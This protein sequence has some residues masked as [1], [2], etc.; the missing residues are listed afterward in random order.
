M[1]S[2]LVFFM[3]AGFAFVESG[4]TRT[5][6][7]I[8][9]AIKN[10]TDLGFSFIIYWV[11]G[12]AFM[13][14][15]SKSGIIGTTLFM[16]PLDTPWLSVFFLFQAMFCSTSATIV[17]GA[18]AERMRYSMYILI[19]IV[20]SSI[21]YPVTGHWGWG[22][23]L[24]GS[25]SGWLAERGFIDFAGSTIVHSV[26][27]W[28]ALAALIII[29]P[30]EGRFV[31]GEAPRKINGSD[32][33]AAVVGVIILWFGWFGFN[34]G[35]TLA[36]DTSISIIII[37]TSLA[38]SAGMAGALFIGWIIFKKPDVEFVTNGAI[39]GLVAITANC[40]AVTPGASIII[41]AVGGAIMLGCSQLFL[42]L[43]INDAVGAIPVHLAAGIWGTLA[44]ALFG[45]P[46]L[47]GTGL[48][49]W[50]Q[51][52]V[53]VEGILAT[54]LW[55]FGVSFLFFYTINK[56]TPF[57]ISPEEEEQ[58]LNIA[59][60][61][62][63]T[64]IYDFYRVLDTQAESGR[65]DLRAPVEP[66]TEI[67][68]IARRYNNLLENLENHV[69]ARSDYLAILN[70]ITDGLFLIDNTMTISGQYSKSMETIFEENGIKGDNFKELLARLMPD[71]EMQNKY[72]YLELLFKESIQDETLEELNPFKDIEIFID[73][74]NGKFHNK[75]LDIDF[76]RIFHEGKVIRVM[77]IIQDLTEQAL[78]SQEVD[79]M[80]K[81]AQTEM[82][83][84]YRIQHINPRIF[85]EFLSQAENSIA[86]INAVLGSVD[87]AP[88][89]KIDTMYRQI[90]T[91]K[92]D[93][94][95][96]ELDFVANKAHDF[97]NEIE[98]LK[99]KDDIIN[100]DFIP[101]AVHLSE[102]MGLFSQ[103]SNIGSRLNA[104]QCAFVEDSV[105]SDLI[106]W[107]IK[108]LIDRTNSEKGHNIRFVFKSFKSDIIPQSLRKNIRDIFVQL[109]RN[110]LSHG[111]ESPEER[112]SAG[113]NEDSL[114]EIGSSM[115]NGELTLFIRDNGRGIDYDKIRKSAID[116][117]LMSEEAAYTAEKDDLVAL[118]FQGSFSTAQE[119]DMN[120]GRGVGMSIVSR[121]I[122]RMNGRM[123][124]RNTPG[125]SLEFEFFIPVSE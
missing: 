6:N 103:L 18:V 119:V 121:L 62:A 109:A 43:H 38:A 107:S 58:G 74:K 117:G 122:S 50:Q 77:G 45:N 83:M 100:Q 48:S 67:G 26:G 9:V 85:S 95:L 20:L 24:E 16:S 57:R 106:S 34:G 97:E 64:E 22:G 124:L 31:K 3:Q 105:G 33:P 47:L 2:C 114:I 79:R 25:A 89:E 60:H 90:H 21:I 53:Q 94:H 86:A 11:V 108:S 81:T 116:K 92:G 69:V 55:A 56:I 78:L 88:E 63:S 46:E 52:Y 30:R 65:F 111:I 39:A 10:L 99:A 17:S 110:A 87:A 104:F 84:F 4:F 66:F 37:N 51:L 54:A 96:L 23:A 42:K 120:S 44:V 123:T 118:I 98:E 112:R 71:T 19:T 91:L 1:A 14:G 93:A 125:E 5:K 12:Y 75:L 40:H 13:F 32:I 8:N 72:D 115:N 61:G 102:M 36:F 82:E 15:L 80:K 73:E 7:S 35:S 27:G 59:E 68:Q 70:N 28:V 49:F 41:G 113:K 101:L 76:R 29:G